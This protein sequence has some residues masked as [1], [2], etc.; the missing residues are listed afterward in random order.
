MTYDLGGTEGH[1]LIAIAIFG[2]ELQCFDTLVELIHRL[3][4][5]ING[6]TS[7]FCLN[8]LGLVLFLEL[9]LHL[10]HDLKSLLELLFG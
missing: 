6:G 4:K 8:L 5:L 7:A 3:Q 1:L 10:L 2:L 9:G